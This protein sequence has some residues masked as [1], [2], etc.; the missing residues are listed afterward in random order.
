MTPMRHAVGVAVVPV[1][2][3]ADLVVPTVVDVDDSVVVDVHPGGPVVDD[4]VADVDV[5]FVR[6]IDAGSVAATGSIRP[7][8]IGSVALTGPIRQIDARSIPPPGRFGKSMPGRLPPPGRLPIS[9]G[10]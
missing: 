2:E 10:R 7:V 5:T 6:P 9:A 1:V 4:V 8:D 3:P